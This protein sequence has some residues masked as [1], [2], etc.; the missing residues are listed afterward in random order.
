MLKKRSKIIVVGA[1]NFGRG[2]RSV[3]SWNLT[4][5]L[6]D[7][8]QIDFL[9][10]HAVADY[11]Y[12][13][14]MAVRRAEIQVSDV[15]TRNPI[16]KPLKKFISQ[17]KILSLNGYEIAHLNVDTPLE[18]LRLVLQAKFAGIPNIIVHGHMANFE[19]LKDWQHKLKFMFAQQLLK[20]M[21]LT[22][23]ACSQEAASF[24][25][26][27]SQH[28]TIIKNG[29]RITDFVFSDGKRQMVRKQLQIK[30]ST[31]VIGTI[32]RLSPSKNPLFILDIL[33]AL[34]DKEVNFHFIWIGDGELFESVQQDARKRN[35]HS[36]I[37]FL[38]NRTDT[39]DLLS[40]MDVFLL[41]SLYEGFGI[42][43]IEAQASGLPCLVS[44]IIPKNVKVLDRL[45]FK[46]LDDPAIKWADKLLEIASQENRIVNV[47]HFKKMGFDIKSNS[48]ELGQIYSHILK[49]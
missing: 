5:P 19:L 14:K 36:F 28:V 7:K 9:S 33:Q 40:A 21:K 31:L 39:P 27:N 44:N 26:G 30:P 6:S 13:D 42:V 15:K 34:K 18:A 4:E 38:G 2:G 8:F 22:R 1:E 17:N 47:S 35:L 25:Y 10:R 23:L 48:E 32:G 11:S 37:S 20:R 24:L 41:P 46:S 12:F 3:I 45:Y 29:I 43:N 16:L 49:L